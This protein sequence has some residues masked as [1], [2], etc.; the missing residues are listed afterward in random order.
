MSKKKIEVEIFEKDIQ[1][2][3]D[4]HNQDGL[5]GCSPD[6][7]IKFFRS[8]FESIPPEYAE[9][10]R[11][12]M[13]GCT[14]FEANCINLTITVSRYETNEEYEYRRYTENNRA[15]YI[16]RSEL[17]QLAELKAKYEGEQ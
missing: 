16:K 14:M 11:V 7:F 13:H 15:D 3:L 10:A 4:S 9:T 17:K 8:K 5:E 2:E 1:E 12:H 6:D